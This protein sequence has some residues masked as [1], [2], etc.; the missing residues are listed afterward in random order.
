MNDQER[1]GEAMRVRGSKL[2][3]LICAC[4]GALML[5]GVLAFAAPVNIK[6]TYAAA[7]FLPAMSYSNAAAPQEGILPE[8]GK[9][10]MVC[11]DISGGSIYISD[12]GYRIGD[13]AEEIQFQGVYKITGNSQE[14]YG[15]KILGGEHTVILDNMDID[16]RTLRQCYPLVVE[17]DSTLHLYLR[18]E[19]TLFAGS[20]YGGI[21]LSEGASMDIRAF[22]QGTLSLLAY[23]EKYGEALIG[24]S[25][26]E[27]SE[28]ATVTYPCGEG[29]CDEVLMYAGTNRLSSTE[30]SRY[31]SQ[32]YLKIQYSIGH[33]CCLLSEPADCTHA[34]YCLECGREVAP[35]AEHVPGAAATCTQPQTCEVCHEVLA[36]PLGHRGVWKAESIVRD[37]KVY[38]Q[39]VMTCTVCE[40]TLV[41]DVSQ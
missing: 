17:K 18:G 13:D 36:G 8:T 16:Q 41:R 3:K 31:E 38:C 28:N 9:L 14:D 1:E 33:E 22:G 6:T 7:F 19:N 5:G 34:Q 10:D 20:G 30:I 40:E 39:E 27:I 24:T 26:I 37:G 21:T 4:A 35:R 29:G 23:P 2:C 32:P 11:L 15:I 12:S 25:A